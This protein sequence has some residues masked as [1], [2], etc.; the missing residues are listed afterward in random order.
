MR[1]LWEI[2]LGA[3]LILLAPY[4]FGGAY[5]YEVA[6]VVHTASPFRLLGG[7]MIFSIPLFL[8]TWFRHAKKEV[9]E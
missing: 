3:L 2:D 6:G 5:G 7:W 8:V 1:V 4:P 9:Q